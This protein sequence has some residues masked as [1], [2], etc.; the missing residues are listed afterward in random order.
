MQENIDVRWRRELLI[1]MIGLPLDEPRYAVAVLEASSLEHPR[2]R[3][4]D[5]AVGVGGEAEVHHAGEQAFGSS[6]RRRRRTP[7]RGHLRVVVAV[8]RIVAS[9]AIVDLEAMLAASRR[10]ESYPPKDCVR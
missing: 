7:Q 10:L 9:N 5:D 8:E 6:L 2:R 3:V 4:R 1:D